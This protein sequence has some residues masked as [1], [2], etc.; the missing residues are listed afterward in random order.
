MGHVH[1]HVLIEM[2]HYAMPSQCSKCRHSQAFPNKRYVVVEHQ[3]RKMEDRARGRLVR[4]I[5]DHN[6]VNVM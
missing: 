5:N 2:L 4:N 6:E 3:A 1:V